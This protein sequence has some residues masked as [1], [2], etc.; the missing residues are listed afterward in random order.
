MLKK[1]IPVVFYLLVAAFALIYLS[2]LDW[3]TI[4][5]LKLDWLWLLVAT[6]LSLALR[7]WYAEIWMLLL[8][9]LGADFWK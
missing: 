7:L 6:V 9:R 4:S 5:T 2:R 3:T 1:L 8:K